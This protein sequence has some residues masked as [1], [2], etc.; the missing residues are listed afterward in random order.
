MRTTLATH[1]SS[2]AQFTLI[3]PSR[4]WDFNNPSDRSHPDFTVNFADE[5]IL[6]NKKF[7]TYPSVYNMSINEGEWI[8]GGDG[9][10]T[11]GFRP[12]DQF[13]LSPLPDPPN[14]N[15]E[16][17]ML[18]PYFAKEGNNFTDYR[19]VKFTS[20]CHWCQMSYE[21]YDIPCY[22][23]NSTFNPYQRCYT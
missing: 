4:N 3:D 10:A 20:S 5:V 8:V 1:T 7:K 21:S 18:I 19:E 12:F 14:F 6:F 17:K 9:S 11:R 23:P 16:G 15:Y 2:H 22:T 13:T